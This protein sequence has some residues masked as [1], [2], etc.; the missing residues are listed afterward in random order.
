MKL[1]LRDGQAW[2]VPVG[3]AGFEVHVVRG[4]VLVTRE[5]DPEDHVLSAPDAFTT[6]ASGRL[7]VWA[8]S[9]AVLE[10]H[11]GPHETLAAA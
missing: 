10:V 4:T 11:A 2:S 9:P 3:H 8:L 1:E 7:A 6:F 5:G